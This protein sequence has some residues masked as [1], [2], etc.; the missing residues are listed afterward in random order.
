MHVCGT[1]SP[2][3]KW[4]YHSFLLYHPH[5][6]VYSTPMALLSHCEHFNLHMYACVYLRVCVARVHVIL[7]M[8]STT[9][10][11]AHS[12]HYMLPATLLFWLTVVAV[13]LVTMFA[14]NKEINKCS[15]LIFPESLRNTSGIMSF[16]D[17]KS[18]IFHPIMRTLFFFTLGYTWILT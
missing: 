1:A 2:S 16:S 9:K 11:W 15:M 8:N 17:L 18:Y 6:P 5:A 12:S 13:S 14:L 4:L 7:Y 10:P 3:C